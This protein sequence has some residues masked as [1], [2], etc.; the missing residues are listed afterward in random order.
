MLNQVTCT[1]LTTAVDDI[2]RKAPTNTPS[3]ALP[4]HAWNN[5]ANMTDFKLEDTRNGFTE[6]QIDSKDNIT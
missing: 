2:E 4:P 6:Q 5:D 1:E 3:E